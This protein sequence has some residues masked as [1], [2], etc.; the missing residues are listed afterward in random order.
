MCRKCML[1]CVFSM[2]MV[3]LFLFCCFY[4]FLHACGMGVFREPL[5]LI[6]CW[7]VSLH[8]DACQCHDPFISPSLLFS[9]HTILGILL[10][11]CSDHALIVSH[12]FLYVHKHVPLTPEGLHYSLH[13]PTGWE[14]LDHH[15]HDPITPLSPLS[16]SIQAVVGCNSSNTSTP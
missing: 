3:L 15:K 14:S 2:C 6:S 16:W 4:P 11:V 12:V 10:N 1:G 8:E 5:L 9:L 7:K 13:V